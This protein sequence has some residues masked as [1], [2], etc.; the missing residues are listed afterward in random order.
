[1]SALSATRATGVLARRAAP[2]AVFTVLLLTSWQVLV[3]VLDVPSFILPAPSDVLAAARVEWPVIA[4]A[5]VVTV[6]AVFIGLCLGAVSGIGMATT[7]AHYRSIA[8]PVLTVAVIVNSAPIVALAPIFNNW[9]GVTNI[10][11]K[12]GIAAVMVFFPVFVNTTRGLLAVSPLHLEV[13]E[14]M[15]ASERQVTREVRLPNALPYLFNGL[16]LGATLSVI[17]V[18]VSEYFGG[19]TKALGVYIAY[20]SALPRFAPAWAGIF[21][22]SGLGLALFGAIVALERVLLPWQPAGSDDG[23]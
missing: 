11:S 3:R 10:M 20:Q 17:G 16:K 13:M 6:K 19:P 2:P 5:S 18:I 8:A 21:V 14:S 7:V 15:A 12:A 9:L 23:A 22:A 4:A 1:M